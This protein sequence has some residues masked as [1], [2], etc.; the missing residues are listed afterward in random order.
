VGAVTVGINRFQD[1]RGGAARFG[2]GSPHRAL[3][4]FEMFPVAHLGMAPFTFRRPT[5]QV[6]WSASNIIN[7][8]NFRERDSTMI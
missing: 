4:V 6:G 2:G 7:L 5:T 3:R 8:A 1:S